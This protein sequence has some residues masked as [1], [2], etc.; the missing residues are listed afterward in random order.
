MPNYRRSKAPGA[1]YFFT[2]VTGRRQPYFD[3]EV[4]RNTFFAAIRKTRDSHPFRIDAWVL[5]PDHF[6]T[7][8]TLPA[9]DADFSQ[10]WAHI[11]RITSNAC[12][13]LVDRNMM[14]PRQVR[15]GENGFWQHR[16]WEHQIRDDTD[17]ATHADYI[18]WN[19]VKH[20]LVE[21]PADWPYSSFLKYVA[22]K[23]YP[24]DWAATIAANTAPFGE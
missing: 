21:R 1:A 4:A 20:G 15:N 16:F 23:I 14:S 6:H 10:R 13:H 22:R 5:L 19:P 12:Q 7:I 17:F 18:H 2:V 9:G 11:K 8:W 3:A 24:N